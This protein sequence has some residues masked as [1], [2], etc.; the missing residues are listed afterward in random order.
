[1]ILTKLIRWN[2]SP[3]P[4]PQFYLPQDFN[5][6]FIFTFSSE[7][8]QELNVQAQGGEHKPGKHDVDDKSWKG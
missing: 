5:F 3:S 2:L 8:E 1:M 7:D 4:L 6:T